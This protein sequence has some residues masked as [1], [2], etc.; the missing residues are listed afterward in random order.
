MYLEKNEWQKIPTTATVQCH[1]FTKMISKHA[2]KTPFSVPN[3][4]A[5]DHL[6][7]HGITARPKWIKTKNPRM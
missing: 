4:P 3:M 2:F 6:A 5:P 1:A 7:N